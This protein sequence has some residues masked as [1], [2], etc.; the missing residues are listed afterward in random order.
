M[1]K[2]LIALAATALVALVALPATAGARDKKHAQVLR[3]AV[4]YCKALHDK[5]G[6]DAFRET[7]GGGRESLRRCVKERVKTL[8]AAR[9]AA[10]RSC[11]QQLKAKG[12]KFQRHGKPDGRA[13]FRKCV[14]DKT[15]TA[16]TNDDEGVLDAVK[17][18]TAEREDDPQGFDDDYSSEEG[19]GDAFSECV[20]DHADDNDNEAEPGDDGDVA[21][22]PADDSGTDE[23]T[24]A[25]SDE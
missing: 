20:A 10:A 13:P 12:R 24:D 3:S 4:S 23:P 2:A 16:T 5:M 1:K 21:E 17:Q 7:Y 9:K 25:P 22:D 11:R 19:A 15:R 6:A 18:C 8:R 14:R